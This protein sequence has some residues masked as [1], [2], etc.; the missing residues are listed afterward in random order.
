MIELIVYDIC[1]QSGFIQV[2]EMK[3]FR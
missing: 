1:W 3:Y 2:N